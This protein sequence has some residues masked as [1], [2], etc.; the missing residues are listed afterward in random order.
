MKG[1]VGLVIGLG[2]GYVL[3][4][5]AGKERYQ[6]IKEQFLKAWNTE[7]VQQQVTKVQDFAKSSVAS[8]PNAVW[9]GAV[10]V[11]NAVT[12]QGTPGEKLDSGIKAGQESAD[13]VK[14]AAAETA[15]AANASF[16]EVAA[17]ADGNLTGPDAASLPTGQI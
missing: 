15:A 14:K 10:K 6:Q 8:L 9:D 2:A 16:D 4:S 11:K 5:R 13:D 17:P 7:P 1:K 3:G 12:K